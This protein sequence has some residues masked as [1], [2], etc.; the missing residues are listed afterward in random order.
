MAGYAIIFV[1]LYSDI[2]FF[3]NK[4]V[5]FANMEVKEIFELRK[6]GR[7]EEAYELIRPMYAAHK[8]KYTTLC[9]FWTASDVLK[10]RVR[11]G[12]HDEAVKIFKAL[13]RILPNIDDRDGRAHRSIYYEAVMLARELNAKA[14][15]GVA[16]GAKPT[17]RFSML[18]FVG[19][20]KIEEMRNEEWTA[21]VAPAVAG[22]PSHM[23]PPVAQ[24]ML[25]IAFQEL[26][27]IPTVDNALKVMPLLQ[28]SVRR[29][30]HDKSNQQYIAFVK[31]I[32]GEAQEK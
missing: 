25:S 30:P 16:D 9:M 6:Q 4:D 22:N 13:L 21:I 3:Q 19:E 14:A 10:K 18:D 12:R 23:I 20:L 27:A 31:T 29:L 24:Q 32:I 26:E 7:V 11:E 15:E 28:E 2:F 8:G 5:T 17:A 1:I